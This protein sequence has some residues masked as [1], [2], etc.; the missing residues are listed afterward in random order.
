MGLAARKALYAMCHGFGEF[1]HLGELVL[2]AHTGA[3]LAEQGCGNDLLADFQVALGLLADCRLRA[4]AD[5]S[6]T[7]LEQE[8]P[9]INNMISFY[10][11][12]VALVTQ[13][14]LANAIV[15]GYRRSSIPIHGATPLA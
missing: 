6:Y 2:A 15:E 5:S 14:D 4:L 1:D 9:A 13:D 8:I 10:E 3:V 11:Q 12:Q 7:L